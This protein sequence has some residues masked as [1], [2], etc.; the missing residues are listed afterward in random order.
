MTTKRTS[1]T[2]TAREGI[3]V[4][5]PADAVIVGVGLDGSDSA[6]L[7]A[8]T[9]AR[10]SDLPVHLVHAVQLAAQEVYAGVDSGLRETAQD[11]L[12]AALARAI[13]LG[14]GQVPVDSTLHMNAPVADTLARA[15]RADRDIVLQHRALGRLHRL[16]APSIVHRVV[17]R[18]VGRVI[19]VPEGWVPSLGP[20]HTSPKAARVDA[21]AATQVPLV[22]VAVQ[23]TKEAAHLLDA[24]FEEARLRHG[25]VRV[26]HAWWMASG[27]D[28]V[29]NED[30]I[31]RAAFAQARQ[32]LQPALD[33]L[34]SRY[35]SVSAELTLRH[36]PPAEAILDVAAHCDLLILGRRQH[37]LPLGS[38]LGPVSRAVLTHAAAPLLFPAE[39]LAAR[40]DA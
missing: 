1:S 39:P 16:F 18:T 7:Y 2:P 21:A 35:P 12:A 37:R 27:Y 25:R 5:I 34:T 8:V 10:R 40:A 17:G 11:V 38:H 3:A 4:S 22:T 33:A 26:V 6:L 30:A 31:A 36:A 29:L 14:E 20:P 23:D 19:S 24:A 13:E 15:A 32:D 28:Q 9:E